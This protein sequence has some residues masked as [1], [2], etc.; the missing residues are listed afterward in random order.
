MRIR[1]IVNGGGA[2]MT[3]SREF[4]MMTF[5]GILSPIQRHGT[6]G[7]RIR[8][9]SAA[10]TDVVVGYL[11]SGWQRDAAVGVRGRGTALRGRRSRR[12]MT[13]HRALRAHGGGVGD[14]VMVMTTRRGQRVRGK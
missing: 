7:S 12:V 3:G 11:E 13:R 5:S 1:I 8:A 2:P 6:G 10:A 9:A 4:V 14:G